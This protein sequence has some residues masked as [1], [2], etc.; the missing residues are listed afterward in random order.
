MC[1]RQLAA[2][3]RLM[4]TTTCTVTSLPSLGVNG[5]LTLV[6]SLPAWAPH[7]DDDPDWVRPVGM[8]GLQVDQSPV[9]PDRTAID[10]LSSGGRPTVQVPVSTIT[11]ASQ[12]HLRLD[13]LAFYL[14][15]HDALFDREGWFGQNLPVLVLRPDGTHRI[16]DG[17]NRVAAAIVRAATV[18]PAFVLLPR[19]CPAPD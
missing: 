2:T 19:E 4:T 11:T 8:V 1:C 5:V 18:V 6:D 17:T 16:L 7:L 3:V 13:A 9:V 10:S 15:N 14:R 12:P